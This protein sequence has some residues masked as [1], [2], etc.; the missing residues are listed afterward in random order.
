MTVDNRHSG[1]DFVDN[2]HGGCDFVDNRHGG[3]DFVDN[4]HSD[5]L[6]EMRSEMLSRID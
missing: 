1:C 5:R 6:F 4:R 3:C 2:R